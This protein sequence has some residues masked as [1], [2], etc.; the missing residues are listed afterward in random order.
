[1]NKVFVFGSNEAGRHGA[2]AAKRAREAYG[3]KYGQGVGLQGSSYA[4]PTKDRLLKTLS[5]DKV[6]R[7]VAEFKK[8]A[9]SN[10]DKV[11]YVTK[12]GTGLA[13]FTNEQIAPLFVGST[14][15]CIFPKEWEKFLG[16]RYRYFTENL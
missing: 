3:A 11:F 9:K 6:S 7:H 10:P 1:M 12:I 4:I 2:G 8:F 5:L 14:E 16:V 15:N 13:A